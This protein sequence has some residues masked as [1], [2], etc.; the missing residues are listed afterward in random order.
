MM[1]HLNYLCKHA[2]KGKPLPVR[3]VCNYANLLQIWFQIKAIIHL[4]EHIFLRIFKSCDVM[5]F[6]AMND[7]TCHACECFL[8][9][10]S[11]VRNYIYIY[12]TLTEMHNTFGRPGWQL[13][14]SGRPWLLKLIIAVSL[15]Q[16]KIASYN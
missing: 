3:K 12:E 1:L 13:I 7:F 11:L 14:H 16:L 15:E 2:T 5:H 9:Q 4:P 8:F 10:A 6:A